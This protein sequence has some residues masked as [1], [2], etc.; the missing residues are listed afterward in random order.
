MSFEALASMSACT[1]NI[2]CVMALTTI[3]REPHSFRWT[4]KIALFC[5]EM[6][7]FF[8]CIMY[9]IAILLM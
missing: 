5:V 3:F 1:I 2:P 8:A 7:L 4:A 6:A 9:Y